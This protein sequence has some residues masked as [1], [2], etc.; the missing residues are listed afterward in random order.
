MNIYILCILNHPEPIVLTSPFPNIT[1][2]SKCNITTNNDYVVNGF[3]ASLFK[4]NSIG[5]FR[6]VSIPDNTLLSKGSDYVSKVYNALP[7]H[8]YS[9]HPVYPLKQ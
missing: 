8:R 7:T 6:V 5:L 9:F 4:I 2:I 3:D 1:N